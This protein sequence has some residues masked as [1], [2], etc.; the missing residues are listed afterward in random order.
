[1]SEK[2]TCPDCGCV[3]QVFYAG[4]VELD[5]CLF[6]RGLWFDGG[7]LDRVL[8]RPVHPE[9][10]QGRTNRKCASCQAPL[11]TALLGGHLVETCKACRGIYLDRG[12]LKLINGGQVKVLQSARPQAVVTFGCIGCGK[13]FPMTLSTR[14]DDGLSCAGCAPGLSSKKAPGPAETSAELESVTDWFASIG[15]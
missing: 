7:E 8:G 4:E 10:H 13:P 11:S 5:R 3:M 14:V 2:R 12:E 9:P 6:C 15:L 1:M